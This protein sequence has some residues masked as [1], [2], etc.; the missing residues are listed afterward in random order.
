ML[1][2]FR[3]K[4]ASLIYQNNSAMS[5]PREY[6]K[7][8][9]RGRNMGPGWG[10]MSM[11]DKDFY[12]GYSYAAIRNR[13]SKTADIAINYLHTESIKEDY[14]H[15][16]LGIINMSPDFSNYKFWS[17][18]ST[19]LDL[20]GV[21][22]LMALRAEGND[23]MGR[24][25]K[26]KLLNPYNITRI[27]DKK[28]MEPS[29]YIES[30]NGQIRE[31]PASMI[32]EIREL[33]PFSDSKPYSMTDAAKE[34]QFTLKTAGDYTRHALKNN[35][36]APGILSTDVILDDKDFRNFMDRVR[37]HTKGEPIFGNGSGA[38]NYQSMQ[39]NLKDSGL[40]EISEINRDSL[41]AVSGVSKTIM[42]IEQSGTTRETSRVQKDL[43]IEGQILPR[44]Q[45]II[46]SLNQDYKNN[47]P[48]FY[49]ADKAE[50]VVSNPLSSDQDSKLKQQDVLDKKVKLYVALRKRG[51][52]HEVA[53]AYASGDAEVDTLENI[54]LEYIEPVPALPNGNN[55]NGSNNQKKKNQFEK[56]ESGLILQQQGALVNAIQQI[57]Q[58]LV[59]HA[60]DRLPKVLKTKKNQVD[61]E[62]F[63]EDKLFTKQQ[64]K[65]SITDLLLI[66]TGFYGIVL[67]LRGSQTM[68]GRTG[69]Y[70]LTGIFSFN[71]E[72]RKYIKETS[73]KIA[74]GH[75]ETVIKEITN[76]TRKAAL[77]GKSLDQIVSD[78]KTQYVGIS[79]NRAKLVARTETNRAFTR[80]QFEADKQ[81]IEQNKL[82]G[83]VY[84]VWHTR[85]DDPCPFCRSLENEGKIPFEQP[86][87]GLGDS[88]DVGKGK[89]K[90]SLS[91]NFESLEAGNAHP[92]CSCTYELIVENV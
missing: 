27:L 42:G 73:Q 49:E 48:K 7:Y 66:M 91:V 20:E 62:G 71:R 17:D 34:S 14:E 89:D 24:I 3:Q 74:D 40:N 81:F 59:F 43:L 5:L 84:K 22:Y 2:K 35:I 55:G 86:F 65:Q 51:I 88:V 77:A 11:D 33:N 28:T 78:L 57:D 45:L 90:K 64:E 23:K 69:E 32:I 25:Q 21:Y 87:R 60:L 56:E 37:N 1:N 47:Y 70:G 79:E 38:I 12:T 83:R 15:P 26:F 10:D 29:G 92:N 67:N 80:A 44:I 58:D 63:D 72:I 6:L 30:R 8:G 52:D 13:A 36:N 19:F 54:D 46:D 61:V 68:R 82:E 16:Y 76:R 53:A 85:S 9:S 75:V 4:I 39:S 41:F 31:L 50:I 18:I